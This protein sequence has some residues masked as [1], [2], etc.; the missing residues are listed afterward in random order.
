MRH[1][2]RGLHQQQALLRRRRK[3]PPAAAFLDQV[4]VIL[5]RFKPQQRQG[6]A[7]LAAR[8]PVAAAAVAAVLGKQG[9]DLVGK[10][11]RQVL[12]DV[13][14][15]HPNRR[16]D[17][18]SGRRVDRRFAFRQRN[19]VA[20]GIHAH[21]SRRSHGVRHL[22]SQIALLAAVK[23]ACHDQLLAGIPARQQEQPV[24]S[25]SGLDRDRDQ[26]A[27]I[28]KSR[29]RL[30]VG[31]QAERGAG[32]NCHGRQEQENRVT[33]HDFASGG[34]TEFPPTSLTFRIRDRFNRVPDITVDCPTIK[35]L[36]MRSRQRGGE[37]WWFGAER[38]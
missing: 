8:F 5:G 35:Q 10:V 3:Q 24:L 38:Q 25:P 30:V 1:L 20:G 18:R 32:E 21:N 29:R 36:F 7:V 23:P 17:S 12:R 34:K 28:P 4:L 15:A 9:R 31:R 16:V 14:H 27:R 6:E 22:A 37:K 13:G 19:H 33:H 2:G 26:F 11:D